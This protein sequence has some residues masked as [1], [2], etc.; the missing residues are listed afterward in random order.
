M[1]TAEMRKPPG[2]LDKQLDEQ[3][4]KLPFDKERLKQEFDL[5]HFDLNQIL[6]G[7]QLTLVGGQFEK[8]TSASTP[9]RDK[10]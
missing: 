10:C 1:A 9:L 4:D 2:K 7:I 8:R 6:R 3:L 5:S